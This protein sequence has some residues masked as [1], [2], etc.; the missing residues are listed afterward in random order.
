MWSREK[1]PG[2]TLHERSD[3][4]VAEIDAHYFTDV[5]LLRDV[6]RCMLRYAGIM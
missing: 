4:F 5:N 3:S 6:M 1:W 2:G